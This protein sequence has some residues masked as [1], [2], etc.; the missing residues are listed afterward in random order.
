LSQIIE[1]GHTNPK[2]Y[3]GLAQN[4]SRT[5]ATALDN[6]RTLFHMRA[7][8]A[9]PSETPYI[10]YSYMGGGLIFIAS[11]LEAAK[12]MRKSLPP[13]QPQTMPTSLQRL[14][15]EAGKREDAERM[16]SI[17]QE[18]EQLGQAPPE[19]DADGGLSFAT[20]AKN[21]TR[22]DRDV[23]AQVMI[24]GDNA[25][26]NVANVEGFRRAFNESLYLRTAT[27]SNQ[28]TPFVDAMTTLWWNEVDPAIGA[29]QLCG[30]ADAQLLIDTDLRY[31][32]AGQ[33]RP[34]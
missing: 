2:A 3:S 7:S 20:T 12:Q 4:V 11:C 16:S 34:Q 10:E 9:E 29:S 23:E 19:L 24:F 17:Y 22:V 27:F 31:T 18:A 5:H 8:A 26:A 25:E 30:A 32:V 21:A 14:L 33:A 6:L 13:Y 15:H 28:Q 1:N